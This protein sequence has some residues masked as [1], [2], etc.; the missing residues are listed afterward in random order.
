[1]AD[2]HPASRRLKAAM[3]LAG[4]SSAEDLAEAIGERGL[5][6]TTLRKFLRGERTPRRAEL[7]LICE[8]VGLPYEFFTADL[9]SAFG[10][11]PDLPA[12]NSARLDRL[13]HTVDA[14]LRV[15]QATPKPA[16]DANGGP[17]LLDLIPE[18]LPE[19]WPLET[20]ESPPD[21]R[22]TRPSR[23]PA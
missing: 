13:E 17:S 1:M 15:L 7:L 19:G 2:T 9:S 6:A 14:I 21:Q 22:S 5:G 3:E 12:K 18:G 16:E 8:A 4:I 23:R 11:A 10:H 20:Q